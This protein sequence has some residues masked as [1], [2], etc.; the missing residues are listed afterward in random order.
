MA[1]TTFVFF[2]LVNS[3]CVRTGHDTVFSRYSLSNRPLLYA[4]AG[5]VAM[6]IM[7]VQLPFL[8]GVFETV[9]L[10]L[11]QWVWVLVTPL[12]LLMFE[13]VRKGILRARDGR[14]K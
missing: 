9:P 14:R 12:L 2:Q 8:Q 1:F 10:S 3:F 7:V 5:V 13:E 4:L 11:E 6:Q